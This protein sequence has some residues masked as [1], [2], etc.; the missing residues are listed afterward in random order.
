MFLPFDAL[1]INRTLVRGLDG[2]VRSPAI[3]ETIVRLGHALQIKV[4]AIGIETG[5]ELGAVRD[6]GCDRAQGFYLGKP[7]TGDELAACIAA[8]RPFREA[9][10]PLRS[11]HR[12]EESF[13]VLG[14]RN[15]LLLG[16]PRVFEGP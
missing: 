16:N 4:T 2:G 7:M 1:E 14:S 3:V 11:V 13:G 6:L 8:G 5:A 12:H 9:T 10:R 15:E